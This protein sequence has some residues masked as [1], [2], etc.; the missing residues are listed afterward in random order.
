MISKTLL[1]VLITGTAIAAPS[2]PVNAFYCPIGPVGICCQHFDPYSFDGKSCTHLPS[3]LLLLH[4]SLTSQKK[5]KNLANEIGIPALQLHSFETPVTTQWVCQS[6]DVNQVFV[7]LC[8]DE[9]SFASIFNLKE[10]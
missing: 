2:V 3:P 4:L 7:E 10:E 8:C 1:V 5:Q 6:E 9:V